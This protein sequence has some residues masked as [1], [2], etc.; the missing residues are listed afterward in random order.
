[1]K[2]LITAVASRTD[3]RGVSGM[4]KSIAALLVAAAAVAIGQPAIVNAGPKEYNAADF[5][6]CSSV[7]YDDWQANKISTKRYKELVQGCCILSGGKWAAGAS[8]SADG[9]C[10]NPASK[11]G[12][13][14]PSDLRRSHCSPIRR[15][16]RLASTGTT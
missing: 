3:G 8:N 11:D 13:P 12:P 5:D 2:S 9:E 14:L 7:A 10:V 6:A 15:W 4:K 16:S 1:M